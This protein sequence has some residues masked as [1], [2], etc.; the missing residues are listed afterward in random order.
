[1]AGD[2]GTAACH[3]TFSCHRLTLKSAELCSTS[4]VFNTTDCRQRS[5]SKKADIRY[6]VTRWTIKNTF[7]WMCRTESSP[8]SSF[9]S[10][11][12]EFLLVPWWKWDVETN[13]SKCSVRP[14]PSE[15]SAHRDLAL[16]S[17]QSSVQ[18]PLAWS[19]WTS[20]LDHTLCC[21]SCSFYFTH[22]WLWM[23]CGLL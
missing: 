9:Q 19:C 11:G 1:M 22:L 8:G 23:Q 12:V 21:P 13:L 4:T 16:S 10:H 5:K 3:C 7:L 2:Q 6:T 15:P 18:P 14:P 17:L 20:A